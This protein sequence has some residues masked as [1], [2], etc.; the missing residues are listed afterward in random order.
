MRRPLVLVAVLG[1][2]AAAVA[3]ES[4]IGVDYGDK[5]LATCNHAEPPTA[6]SGGD[7]G[8]STT[9]TAAIYTIDWGDGDD[10]QG[11][12]RAHSIGYDLDNLCT[13]LL[14]APRCQPASWTGVT[15]T[16]GPGGIDNA[17]GMLLY[18]QGTAFGLKPFTSSFLTQST[19]SGEQAPPGILRVSQY[20][21]FTI[22]PQVTVE[23][24]VPLVP[25][26]R[27]KWDGTDTWPILHGTADATGASGIVSHYLDHAAYVNGYQLVA[28]F[29]AG[30][31]VI[32]SNVPVQTT[33]MLV[34]ANL[35]QPVSGQ[36]QLDKGI[37]AG[38]GAMSELFHDL[39]ALSSS[40][41][42]VNEAGKPNAICKNDTALYAKIKTWLC[43]HFDTLQGSG[44]TCDAASFG[45]GF[46]ARPG[47]VGAVAPLAPPVDYCIPGGDPTGDTCAT[48]P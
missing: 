1:A 28:H 29:P 19:Q 9:F 8:D 17:I 45:M 21:G 44:P 6:P 39:P 27:P 18:D 7:T 48:P 13:G 35:S 11:N 34:T 32:I 14:D 30:A 25:G 26:T 40:F 4:L 38:V 24:F 2:A 46:T 23:W 3:C 15:V 42:G 43:S 41:A 5:H 31:P 47:N 37:V 36:W 10:A 22:D 33:S 16:D 12:A 20:S